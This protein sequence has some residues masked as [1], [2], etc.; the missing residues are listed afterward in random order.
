[1]TIKGKSLRDGP[2]ANLDGHCA[3]QSSE[4][5]VGTIEGWSKKEMS[6]ITRALTLIAP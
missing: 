3:Q 1:M 5:Q 4:K 6:P 2:S